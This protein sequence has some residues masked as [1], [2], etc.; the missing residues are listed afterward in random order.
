MVSEQLQKKI[1]RAIKLLQTITPPQGQPIEVCYSGGK[2]SDVILQLAKESGINYKAIY[3]NTTIDPPGT[4]AHAIEMGAEVVKPKNGTFR[5]LVIRKGLPSRVRRFCCDKLKEYKILDK[6]IVGVRKSES[7]ARAERY[8]EPTQCRF[9]GSKKE[10]VEQIL[11]ILDWTDDDVKEFIEDRGIK[12]APIYYDEDGN[13]V[14][15]RRLGCMCCPMQ[16]KKKR[17]EEFKKH[18]G[19]VVFYCHALEEFWDTHPEASVRKWHKTHYEQFVHDVFYP[20]TKDWEAHKNGL[21][22]EE[23]DYKKFLEDYFNIKL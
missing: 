14:V 15:E 11:P 12:C 1:D 8:N 18:P 23:I 19:M 5:E 2:D 3:K 20:E 4:I 16:S 9:Y 6:A 22:A 13:F 10:H 21:F 17:I 7:R